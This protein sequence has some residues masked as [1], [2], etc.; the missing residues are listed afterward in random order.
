MHCPLEVYVEVIAQAFM[1]LTYLSEIL[2]IKPTEGFQYLFDIG[3]N[4][5]NISC[6]IPKGNFLTTWNLDQDP[7]CAWVGLWVL[8]PQQCQMSASILGICSITIWCKIPNGKVSADFGFKSKVI[9]GPLTRIMCRQ[10]STT[11]CQM[12][13]SRLGDGLH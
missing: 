10:K 9:H 12:L 13:I 1:L 7:L 2:D 4:S 8:S 11:A 3:V 6:K 5:I